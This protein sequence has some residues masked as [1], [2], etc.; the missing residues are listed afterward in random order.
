ML[1]LSR[2]LDESII[3]D[4]KIKV[5]II[6]INGGRVKLGVDAPSSITVNREE[7]EYANNSKEDVGVTERQE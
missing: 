5:K 7:I 4:G 2:K 6:G 3:I 1:V